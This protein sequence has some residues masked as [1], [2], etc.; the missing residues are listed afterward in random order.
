V[1][2]LKTIDHQ[3]WI[4]H[5]VEK[6]KD[7]NRRAFLYKQFSGDDGINRFYEMMR[8]KT[9]ALEFKDGTWPDK[10]KVPKPKQIES[11]KRPCIGCGYKMIRFTPWGELFEEYIPI[12][13]SCLKAISFNNQDQSNQTTMTTENN[14]PLS[15]IQSYREAQKRDA[16]A[17]QAKINEVVAGMTAKLVNL[18]KDAQIQFNV[19]I[20]PDAGVPAEQLVNNPEIAAILKTFRVSVTA[21]DTAA[22]TKTAKH[23]ESGSKIK[24]ERDWILELLKDGKEMTRPEMKKAIKKATGKKATNIYKYVS[25]LVKE[26]ILTKGSKKNSFKLK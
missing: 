18:L 1:A 20:S 10:L 24:T 7:A 14:N 16:E 13:P 5:E 17:A 12:C 3:F 19:L 23:D 9:G 22:K 26:K 6:V 8:S 25:D 15:L 4:K 2:I 21:K 11:L